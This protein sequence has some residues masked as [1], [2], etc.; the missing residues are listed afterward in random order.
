MRETGEIHQTV[1]AVISNGVQESGE[2][3][4]GSLTN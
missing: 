4:I 1:Q 2:S 3:E